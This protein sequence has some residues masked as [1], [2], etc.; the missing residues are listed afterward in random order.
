MSENRKK[1]LIVGAGWTGA[2]IANILQKNNLDIMDIDIIEH[3]EAFA[4]ASVAVQ[5]ALK[6][7]EDRF[8]VH[9]GA[10]AVGHP[11]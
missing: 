7:P 6:V 4:A 9:G 8:N 5:M 2:T 1:V 3:N 11:L 10:V